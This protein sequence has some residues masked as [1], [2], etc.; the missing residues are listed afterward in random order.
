M[1]IFIPEL[2]DGVFVALAAEGMD[3]FEHFIRLVF[4][5]EII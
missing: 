1:G 5:L 2:L 3:F 4:R